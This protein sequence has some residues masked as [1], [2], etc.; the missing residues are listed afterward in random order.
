ML[1]VMKITFS[2]P[3]WLYNETIGKFPAKNRSKMIE[4]L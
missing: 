4:E 3:E 2:I 1:M